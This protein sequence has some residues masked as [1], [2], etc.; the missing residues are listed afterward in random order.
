VP[1][2]VN[3]ITGHRE[4]PPFGL[5]GGKPGSLGVNQVRRA[6]GSVSPLKGRDR[7]FLEAGEAIV[8]H[9]P[10]GGGFG[11]PDELG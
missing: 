10:G 8:M 6:D 1:M 5:E 4:I 2:E 3:L 9:T 7:M 11:S